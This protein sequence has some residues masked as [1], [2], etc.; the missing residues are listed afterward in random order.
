M[1]VVLSSRHSNLQLSKTVEVV[2]DPR[3]FAYSRNALQAIL[4]MFSSVNILDNDSIPKFLM[5][6]IT[7]LC[8]DSSESIM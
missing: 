6:L 7:Y 5:D 4:L 8:R 3:V 2:N 1:W